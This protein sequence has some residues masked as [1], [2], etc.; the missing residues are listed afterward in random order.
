METDTRS[1]L[2]DLIGELKDEQLEQAHG[3]LRQLKAS[4]HWEAT[5]ETLEFLGQ[6]DVVAVR[7]LPERLARRHGVMGVAL[8]DHDSRLELAMSD[9]NDLVA[10]D[11]VRVVTGMEIVPKAVD[12]ELIQ[13]AQR[14]F[15]G[16]KELQ[17]FEQDLGEL[18]P[19]EPSELLDSAELSLEDLKNMVDD[20]PI[21]RVVNLILSQAIHDRA[22][23]IHIDPKPHQT[24]V[25]YRVDGELHTV[26]TPPKH[27][28]QHVISRL[29]VISGLEIWKKSSFASGRL[30]L[31]HDSR[32]YEMLVNFARCP[33]GDKAVI[34]VTDKARPMLTYAELGVSRPAALRFNQLLERQ[35]GLLVVT[36]PSRSGLSTLTGFCLNRLASESRHVVSYQE[37][38]GLETGQL[39][40]EISV[41]CG[42]RKAGQDGAETIESLRL[43]DPDVLH[44][45]R[46][47]AAFLGGLLRYSTSEGI[48][49]ST[50]DLPHS[51]AVLPRL[52][53]MGASPTLLA[54]GLTGVV[55]QRLARKLCANCK[56]T[57]ENEL[58]TF[59]RG[60]GCEH[61][62]DRGF[63]GQVGVHELLVFN[64]RL[65]EMLAT[66]ANL[67]DLRQAAED[68]CLWTLQQDCE[69]KAREGN[70]SWDEFRRLAGG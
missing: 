19:L 50:M 1:Q 24:E 6:L 27:I 37:D 34:K 18:V 56:V 55:S 43:L 4:Q 7:A 45:P 16:L 31:S 67:V 57:M 54:E 26:M 15:Y 2:T 9:I 68:D 5:R 32:P 11:E 22:S 14:H 41:I 36:G 70:I 44:L 3:F 66:G 69:L 21:I 40:Q 38:M 13:A 28:H 46:I 53:E 60:R 52:L 33:W 10:L 20:A 30:E 62:R 39:S 47:E 17:S 49:V 35:R 58:G 59:W 29:K 12:A 63:R 25:R 61:C 42:D 48:A 65:R 23:H 64:A 51:L 8:L